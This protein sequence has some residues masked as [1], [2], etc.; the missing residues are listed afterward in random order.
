M[1]EGLVR[2]HL[3]EASAQ[4]VAPLTRG[5]T[6]GTTDNTAARLPGVD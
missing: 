5:R 1:A 4:G 6:P 2:A 3:A